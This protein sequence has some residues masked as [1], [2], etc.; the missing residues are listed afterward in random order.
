MSTFKARGIVLRETLVNDK[1]KVLTVL[2]KDYGKFDIWARNSRIS[3]SRFIASTALFSYSDFIIYD[4]G[5]TLSLNQADLIENFY[6]LT[7]DLDPLAYGTYFLE[8]T[9]KSIQE[10]KPVNNIMLLLLKSLLILSKSNTISPKLVAKIFEL[11]FLELNGYM[12]II[13]NCNH[14][15]KNIN[16]EVEQPLYFGSM[17]LV[18]KNCLKKELNL[19]EINNSVIYTLNYIFSSDINN[20]Y[21]FNIS[22]DLLN[23]ISKI[24]KKLLDEHLYVNIKSKQFIEEIEKI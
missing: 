14:C 21:K 1:D 7:E 22:N 19:I 23:T 2:L 5:K 9:D 13:N 4:N 11:K 3:K 12:P 8:L 10:A 16:T 17:G 6:N 24:S 15:L 20:L 18:C